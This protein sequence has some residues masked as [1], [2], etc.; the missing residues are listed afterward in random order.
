MTLYLGNEQLTLDTGIGVVTGLRYYDTGGGPHRDPLLH[1][2]PDR[3]IG[4][5]PEHQHGHHRRDHPGTDPSLLHRLRPTPRRRTGGWVDNRTLLD[6]PTD[7]AAGLNLLGAR[8]YDPATG[9]IPQR[10]PVLEANDPNQL[11]GYTYAGNNPVAASDPTGLSSCVKLEDG[12]GPCAQN[13]NTP[14]GRRMLDRYENWRYRQDMLWAAYDR[15]MGRLRM[16]RA[17]FN[18]MTGEDRIEA[19]QQTAARIHK[20]VLGAR[21][22]Q[23]HH[24]A[25]S[26]AGL[27][28]SG[29]AVAI[30]SGDAATAAGE[31]LAKKI[32]EGTANEG[33]TTGARDILRASDDAA[34]DKFGGGLKVLNGFGIVTGIGTPY[35]QL[36]V[37]AAN[38]DQP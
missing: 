17:W 12:D 10:G 34:K 13:A 8:V 15:Y 29:E 31:A 14:Q 21:T 23:H 4:Q 38:G 36:A 11:G 20:Q 3:R 24:V 1:R 5:R 9:R 25:F 33:A 22:K 18:R 2:R 19:A 7:A 32:A 16:W 35:G 37:D 6:Q 30:M 27:G 28:F 26:V